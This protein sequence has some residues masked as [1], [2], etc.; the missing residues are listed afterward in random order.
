MF[1][2][3]NKVSPEDAGMVKRA[4]G[5]DAAVVVS[6]SCCAPGTG[7]TDEAA[8]QACRQVLAETGLDWPV[9]TVTVT[10]AQ[11]IIGRIAAQLDARQTALSQQVTQLFMTQGL[12]AFPVL[13]MNQRVVAY[14]GVP[15]VE[16][17][18]DTLAKM[19]A[20]QGQPIHAAAS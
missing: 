9:I 13:I 7:E 18:R 16:L 15:G 2:F 17:L 11:S 3:F 8:A 1:G 14:G 12:S 5:P 6:A 20:P 4:L 10:Q 19:K